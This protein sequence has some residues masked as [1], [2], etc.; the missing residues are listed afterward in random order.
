[1]KQAISLDKITLF[2]E[3]LLVKRQHNRDYLM[4]LETA[5]LLRNHY[6]EAGLWQYPDQLQDGHWGWESPTSQLRGHF[7]GHWLS[8]AAMMSY[9]VQEPELRAK[10]EFIVSELGRCQ[11]ANG[12][13]WV[14]A[15]PPVYLERL[16]KGQAVW[17]PQYNL[18]KTFMGLL[19]AYR[20]MANEAALQIAINWAGWFLN[21][22]RSF[23]REQLD[24]IL[25]VETGGMLEVWAD[26]YGFTEDPMYLELIE[27]YRRP[28]LFDPL[29]AGED[30]LTNKHANTT[31]PEIIGAARVYEVT[32]D[33]KWRE[34]VEVYWQHAVTERGYFC[35]GGQTSGEV[36]TPANE[37]S[38]RIGDR[39]QEHCSVYHMII[40][41]DLLFRWTG[42]KRYADYI[43][44]NFRNG[45]MAQ[46]YVTDYSDRI[47]EAL[48]IEPD[49]EL[50][51]YYLPLRAGGQKSWGSKRHHFWCCHGTLVQANASHTDHI[52]YEDGSGLTIAQYIDSEL[53]WQW[54][55]T[56]V[57]VR[58]VRSSQAGHIQRI[59][60][61]A[62]EQL[63]LPK[64]QYVTLEISCETEQSFSLSL[65]KP[66][67]VKG[68]VTIRVNGEKRHDLHETDGYYVLE[69]VWHHDHITIEW[70]MAL[71][72]SPLPDEPNK[73]AFM[74]GP[75]VLAGLV[76]DEITLY[77][78]LDD[79]ESLLAVDD[80]RE[81]WVWNTRFRTKGQYQNIRFMPLNR[82][83]HERYTVYFPVQS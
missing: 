24:E 12:G 81:W 74:Y 71:S 34:I 23:T 30:P 35:T 55:N 46:G 77:G 44:R 59:P 28:R 36:W 78:D 65:R 56:P 31:I 80:E 70:P 66:W 13:Q 75:D 61:E 6:L 49:A 63:S 39:T 11:E 19:D 9:A 82:I 83:C 67:W 10:A 14:G 60:R 4:E 69:Q 68:E 22:V 72:A 5:H 32:G 79:L 21:W 29:L 45:I 43:E 50:I 73:V 58:M 57:K 62:G 20:Y 42:D 53:H 64:R 52:Y 25:D 48:V 41:A 27:A 76:E 54:D 8:A 37:L 33:A 47:G 51:T 16:A 17:V 1:M 18:H 26:L 15:V 7:L 40:L 38:A 2:D 3:A